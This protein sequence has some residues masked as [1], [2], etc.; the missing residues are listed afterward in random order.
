MSS[1]RPRTV[2]AELENSGRMWEAGKAT[3]LA[4]MTISQ[5]LDY[6]I[7]LIEEESDE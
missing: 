7:K 5:Q 3:V 2:W 6:L 4:L 1:H